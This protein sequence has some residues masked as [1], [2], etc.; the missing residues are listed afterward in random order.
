M[1]AEKHPDLLRE[2]VVVEVLRIDPIVEQFF[3][4]AS[5]SCRRFT[6]NL[7]GKEGTLRTFSSRTRI[8]ADNLSRSTRMS[9]WVPAVLSLACRLAQKGSSA[10]ASVPA[11]VGVR[12]RSSPPTNYLVTSLWTVRIVAVAERKARRS[13]VGAISSPLTRLQ[14]AGLRTQMTKRKDKSS[15]ARALERVANATRE[16]HPALV[17]LEALFSCGTSHALKRQS[18]R[19]LR[20]PYRN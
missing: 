13:A 7:G 1:A 4:A 9:G 6:G 17:A 10:V 18:C 5:A 2:R 12:P 3:R 14:T 20:P 8:V 16:V 11:H 15:E 19:A